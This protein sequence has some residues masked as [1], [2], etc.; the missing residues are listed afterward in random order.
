MAFSIPVGGIGGEN[1]R[2]GR[3]GTH[4]ME[5]LAKSAFRRPENS[6]GIGYGEGIRFGSIVKWE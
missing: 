2:L 5:Q 4:S 6:L 3:K 1:E